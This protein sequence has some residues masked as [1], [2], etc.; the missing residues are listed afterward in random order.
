MG[1]T[2]TEKLSFWHLEHRKKQYKKNNINVRG[3]TVRKIFHFIPLFLVNID[4]LFNKRTVIVLNDNRIKTNKSVIFSVTHIGGF[5]IEATFQAI[6]SSAWLMLG[7]PKEIYH[8]FA[9]LMLWLNGVICLET[10]DKLDRQIGKEKSIQV[11]QKGGKIMMFPEGAWNISPNQIV[12]HMYFGAVEMAIKTDSQIV[13][14]GVMREGNK[15]YVNIGKNIDYSNCKIEDKKKLTYEL[16]DEMTSLQYETMLKLP[17]LHR[18]EITDDYYED[19]VKGVIDVQTATYSVD[20]IYET[21][22]NPNY[23]TDP[24]EAFAHLND[25]TPNMNNAFLFNKRL[26]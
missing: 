6:K 21:R 12:Y 4:G 7:D 3:V 10:R 15:Y 22:F 13:P 9:G 18:D 11:L 8:N 2:F 23:I 20:E 14:I 16:R 25:I 24:S 26:L 17:L 5:D 19:F 1:S